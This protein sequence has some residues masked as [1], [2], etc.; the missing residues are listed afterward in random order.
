M[1]GCQVVLGGDS[2]CCCGS[3]IVL[4]IAR[5]SRLGD[6]LGLSWAA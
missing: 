2:S 6:S 1:S 5:E 4:A 3:K